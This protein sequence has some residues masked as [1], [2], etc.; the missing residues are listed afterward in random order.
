MLRHR[1]SECVRWVRVGEWNDIWL[2]PIHQVMPSC[3]RHKHVCVIIAYDFSFF[4]RT[5]ALQYT[6][7]RRTLW[8]TRTN[9]SSDISNSRGVWLPCNNVVKYWT[10][11]SFPSPGPPCIM[12]RKGTLDNFNIIPHF[13]PNKLRSFILLEAVHCKKQLLHME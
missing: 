6:D 10:E 9:E 4:P 11:V 1:A 2:R 13:F 7:T 5:W 8:L 12:N 3:F